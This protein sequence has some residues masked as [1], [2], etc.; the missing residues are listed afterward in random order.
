M[1]YHDPTHLRGNSVA[2]PWN[3][4]SEFYPYCPSPHP[5]R[6]DHPIE[7][8]WGTHGAYHYVPQNHQHEPPAFINMPTGSED[9]GSSYVPGSSSVGFSDYAMASTPSPPHG[10]LVRD[11][12]EGAGYYEGW[13]RG[14]GIAPTGLMNDPH[15][16]E[17]EM[18]YS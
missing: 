13:N 8:P 12:P 7:Y 14:T 10:V 18:R 3:A 9:S 4:K 1:G 6:S 5:E 16:V 15:T 2:C 11:I 17:R